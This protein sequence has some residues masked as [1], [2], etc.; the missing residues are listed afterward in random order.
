MERAPSQNSRRLAAILAIDMVAY[1]RQMRADEDATLAALKAA[2]RQSIDPAI[3]AA[4]GRIFK[5]MGDGLLCEFPSVVAAV[6]CALEIQRMLAA[7]STGD[8]DPRFRIGVSLGDVVADSDD[9]FGDGVNMAARLQSVAQPGGI[10]VSHVVRDQVGNR[11]PLTFVSRGR[12]ALKNIPDPVE[13]F[14][15]VVG[16]RSAPV[17]RPHIR[18]LAI[19]AGTILA[20][21]GAGLAAWRLN[22]LPS[23]FDSGSVVVAASSTSEKAPLVAVLPFANRSGDS[24][25]DYFSDGMTED[26]IAALGQFRGLAVLARSAVMPFK[27][28]ATP[29]DEIARRL[30]ARYVVEGDVRRS[31]DRV[32]VQARL[33]DA[34]GG[35]VL[36]SDRFDGDARDLFALQDEL[37]R[38]VAGT[39]ASRVGRVEQERIVRKPFA[40]PTAYELV[41]RGRAL[42]EKEERKDLVE[43]RG[44][45]EQALS[46][47]PGS[48]DARIG[49]A[50]VFYAYVQYGY[51]ASITE[52]LAD[53]EKQL[54]DALRL[55]PTNARAQGLL[56][57]VLTYY[58]RFDEA[59][60]AIDRALDLNP[61]DSEAQFARGSVLLWS[62]RTA[63]ALRALEIGRRLDPYLTTERFFAV[64]LANF[65]LGRP[66]KSLA[67]LT[68]AV[69]QSPRYQSLYVLLAIANIELGREDDAKAAAAMAKRLDPFF[70]GTRFGSRLR[71]PKQ[72]EK[73]ADGM[74]RV[75]LRSD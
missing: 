68:A 63:E 14:D 45:F 17:V 35:Q 60:E 37:V 8:G 21:V 42:V 54:R 34:Q 9:L 71:D 69:A 13:V 31:G 1:S 26:I 46:V 4:G 74:R 44:Y 38:Q 56:G 25:Q 20:V 29:P 40:N 19:A 61:S 43:A 18:R 12:V 47:S 41:L 22:L 5:T 50:R 64:A 67:E 72:R 48:A 57:R 23:L 62:G 24:S 53:A 39:L 49:L 55:D 52:T 16:K 58:G 70:D 73:I 36:W 6:S 3:T 51:T 65:L 30:G 7:S 15:V 59:L 27:S 28:T 32:R 10:A 11:L 75:G 33:S 2:R 66:D